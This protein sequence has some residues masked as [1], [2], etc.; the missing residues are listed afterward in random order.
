MNC[1]RAAR[2]QRDGMDGGKVGER[3]GGNGLCQ[4]ETLSIL[5]MFTVSHG[6]SCG[7]SHCR[8]PEGVREK[9]R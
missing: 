5:L 6:H 3:E 2:R 8:F 4:A 9:G 1:I 7:R